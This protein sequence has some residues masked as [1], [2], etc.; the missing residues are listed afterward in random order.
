MMEMERVPLSWSQEAEVST[1][2]TGWTLVRAMAASS[3]V[4]EP[5]S[6]LISTEDLPHRL[7][8][9]LVHGVIRS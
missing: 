2:P 3:G 8:F 7:V 4:I 6:P 5:V 9:Q 1:S